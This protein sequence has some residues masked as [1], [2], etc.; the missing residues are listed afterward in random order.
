MICF[1]RE[2]LVAAE[3]SEKARERQRLHDVRGYSGLR[4][5]RWSEDSSRSSCAVPLRCPVRNLP[6]NP[7]LQTVDSSSFALPLRPARTQRI[8]GRLGCVRRTSVGRRVSSR[9]RYFTTQPTWPLRSTY[10][11]DPL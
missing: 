8:R 6:Q 9:L 2:S 11:C 4:E 3:V 7:S 5:S 10:G 1:L